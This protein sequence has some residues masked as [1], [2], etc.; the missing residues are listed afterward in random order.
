MSSDAAHSLKELLDLFAS[1]P[2][3][4]IKLK[5]ISATSY[6]Q[7][8]DA[9][10]AAIDWIVGEMCKSARHNGAASEDSLTTQMVINLRAMGFQAMHD[11]DVGGHCDIVVEGRDGFL[12]L[13]EAKIHNSYSWLLKGLRQLT[14]RYSTGMPGQ[15][16]GGLIIYSR[17]P[18][19]D[20]TMSTW[21]K[22]LREN[23]RGVTVHPC[24]R[25]SAAFLSKHIHTRTGAEFTVRHIPVS[26]YHEPKDG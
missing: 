11:A 5:H 1:S 19:I 22:H 17:R 16:N 10:D 6:E 24:R 9:L 20:R 21:S 8:L 15:T 25:V 7:Q 23:E 12:W 2:P 3:D 4:L 13:A 26:L 14:T 18:R